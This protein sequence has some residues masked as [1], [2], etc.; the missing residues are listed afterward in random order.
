MSEARERI[1]AWLKAHEKPSIHI[2]YKK[3]E[4]PLPVGASKF[5]GCPD[6]PAGFVWPRFKGG[7]ELWDDDRVDMERPLSFMAQFDLAEVSALDAA[8][9]LPKAG[10]LAFF[11][12]YES[13]PWGD[14]EHKGCAR[15]FYFPP[16]AALERTVLPDDMEKEAHI[17]E[18][19]LSFSQRMSVPGDV[20]LPE[21]LEDLVDDLEK[22]ETEDWPTVGG[23]KLLGWA[24]PV[25]GSVEEECRWTVDKQEGEEGADVEA[26]TGGW[27]LLLQFDEVHVPDYADVCFGDAGTLYFLIRRQDLAALDFENIWA[28]WQCH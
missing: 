6:L 20:A 3:P 16:E 14:L 24:D 13:S 28:L 12:D 25:Q 15:V 1:E 22:E 2:E 9:L 26:R 17:P 18:L 10:H 21:E 7:E 23:C 11:Y 27:M 19:A 8:G 5:G 4:A